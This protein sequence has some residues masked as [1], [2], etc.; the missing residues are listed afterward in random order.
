MGRYSGQERERTR[1]RV[2]DWIRNSGGFDA[3]V[4]FDTVLRDPDDPSCLHPDYNSGDNLH[5]NIRA[6]QAMAD[7]FPLH[8]FEE[9][10]NGVQ[11]FH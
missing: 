6:F 10:A 3:V 2:N 8:I 9:L 4:D 11:I 5:P 7:L 1:Q